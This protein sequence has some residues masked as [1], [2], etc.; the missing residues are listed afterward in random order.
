MSDTDPLLEQIRAAQESSF[1]SIPPRTP[2]GQ[3]LPW[4]EYYLGHFFAPFS[5]STIEL[6]EPVEHYCISIA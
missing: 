6:A 4:Q 2:R 1:G 3:R 5:V